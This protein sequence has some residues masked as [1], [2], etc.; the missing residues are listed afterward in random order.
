[1]R[2]RGKVPATRHS[3]KPE[4]DPHVNEEMHTDPEDGFQ[5]VSDDPW[6]EKLEKRLENV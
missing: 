3:Q 2:C 6:T 1:M 5:K 4:I